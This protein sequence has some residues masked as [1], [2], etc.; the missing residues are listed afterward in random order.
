[1]AS[2]TPEQLAKINRFSK[3]PLTIEDVVVHSFRMIGTKFIPSRYL[4][5]DASL[6]DKYLANVNNGD[7][8]QIADHSFSGWGGNVTLPFGRFFEGE[9]VRDG[10][11]VQLDGTMFMPKGAKTYIGDYTTD[12]IDQQIESGILFDS[13]VSVTWGFS[14]CSICHC[15]IRDWQNCNHWP[16]KTYEQADGSEALCY[17]IAKPAPPPRQDDS[18]MIE[19]SIVCAGAYP[20]A[21]VLSV[22]QSRD[23]S[24]CAQGGK[25]VLNNMADL[26][27]VKQ[28]APV[29][30]SLSSNS[31]TFKIKSEDIRDASELHQMQHELYQMDELPGDY[32]KAK[33]CAEHKKVVQE[34]LDA[35]GEHF[36]RDAL[37]GAL[38]DALKAR[39][40]KGSE[41][42]V[43]DDEKLAFEQEI[44]ELKK[45]L[46]DK[47]GEIA[48]LKEQVEQLTVNAE[49]GV[50]YREDVI[51]TALA[52]GVRD[53]GNEF[54]AD[55]YKKMFAGLSIDEIKEMGEAWEHSA[56]EKLGVVQHTQGEDLHLPEKALSSHDDDDCY[57]LK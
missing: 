47:D 27:L 12:D 22:N 20:D 8:V 49:L 34:I 19:N 4:R 31:A 24:I 17:V 45:F 5:F 7:V 55:M 29:F 41:D 42:P 48:S 54:K 30:C 50:K 35:G 46:T 40:K 37:D 53:Q 28:D 9:L 21:G 10:A 23:H 56:L 43:T 36:M 32:T 11:D 6:L 3:I 16:G 51:E 52:S 26:K 1:M 2:P 44:T 33:L 38:N 14:E 25:T 57:V 39:S 15:D 13:S 18:M